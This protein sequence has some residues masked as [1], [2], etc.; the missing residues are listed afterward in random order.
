[1]SG[2]LP[3]VGKM[4]KLGIMRHQLRMPRLDG[5]SWTFLLDGTIVIRLFWEF[6]S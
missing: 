6:G 5:A 2:M 3:K 4:A 1:M